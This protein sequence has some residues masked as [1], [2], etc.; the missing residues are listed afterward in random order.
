MGKTILNPAMFRG[1]TIDG[2]PMKPPY[3]NWKPIRKWEFH[4]I[5]PYFR[6][7][8]DDLARKHAGFGDPG[9]LVGMDGVGGG[10]FRKIS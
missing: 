3:S 2:N 7:E 1:S 8:A 10:G 9:R 6:A 5:P 4:R